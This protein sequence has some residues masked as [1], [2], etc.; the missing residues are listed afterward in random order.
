V[1]GLVALALLLLS[2]PG[3]VAAD[4]TGT[5]TDEARLRARL[6]PEVAEQVLAI[7]R[8]ARE[9]SLPV[10]PLI[11]RALEGA[12]RGADAAGIVAGVR[13][14]A[15]ALGE[16]R[17]ALGPG[18]EADEIVAGASALMAGVPADS[19]ARLRTARAGGSLVIPLVVLCDLVARG[20]PVDAASVAVITAARAGATDLTLLRIRERIHTRIDSG[21]A[22]TVAA[23][24]IVRQW[25]REGPGRSRPGSEP[26]GGQRHLP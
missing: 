12:S 17:G 21:G 16:A 8:E 10:D 13:R 3:A 22:P 14:Q 25:L 24:E 7:V 6:T 15:A 20:V 5:P 2:A 18:A 19:L 9:A 26:P 23:S 1:R 11:A 4:V